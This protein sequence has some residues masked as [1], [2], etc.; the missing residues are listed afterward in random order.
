M[1]SEKIILEINRPD[2]TIEISKHKTL[3]SIHKK[4]N[5]IEY[6]KLRSIYRFNKGE[7]KIHPEQSELSKIIK[8]YDNPDLKNKYSFDE[9]FKKV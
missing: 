9:L 3:K 4:L 1:S 5:N 7:Q 6:H 8:I 2:G